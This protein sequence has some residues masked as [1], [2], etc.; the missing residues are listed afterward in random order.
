MI[1]LMVL[2]ILDYS[3]VEPLAGR[4][5]Q[6]YGFAY[7]SGTDIVEGCRNYLYSGGKSGL[8]N[9]ASRT[10]VDEN[11]I[12]LNDFAGMVPTGETLPVVRPYHKHELVVRIG[13]AELMERGNSVRRQGEV[14]LKI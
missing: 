2:D 9:L 11:G 7:L 12:M 14:P 5:S 8:V 4:L 3:L 13:L 10:T 6:F 1:E